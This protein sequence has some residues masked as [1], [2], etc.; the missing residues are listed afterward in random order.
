MYIWWHALSYNLTWPE[1]N[2]KVS[3]RTVALVKGF[4]LRLTS[5]RANWQQMV[6]VHINYGR[7]DC[8]VLIHWKS[9]NDWFIKL[10]RGPVFK[11]IDRIKQ[12]QMMIAWQRLGFD[13]CDFFLLISWWLL[14]L[15]AFGSIHLIH[16]VIQVSCG[17]V[18]VQEKA[19]SGT[20]AMSSHC[21]YCTLHSS[22]IYK[23]VLRY[24]R[25]V[26]KSNW[27]R[28]IFSSLG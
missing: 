10:N 6:L 23:T 27:P 22:P 17:Y 20:F 1:A 2:N 5:P 21:N 19:G 11:I 12:S 9:T 15:T 4:W 25:M 8:L 13:L 26:S 14:F 18:F 28:I 16:T 7:G 3:H 24:E